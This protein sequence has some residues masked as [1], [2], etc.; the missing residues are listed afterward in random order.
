M[1]VKGHQVDEAM[2]FLVVPSDTIRGNRHGKFHQKMKKNFCTV[3]LK[4]HWKRL[5]REVVE[6]LV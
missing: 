3:R 2:L 5:P 1:Q 6:C 4:E